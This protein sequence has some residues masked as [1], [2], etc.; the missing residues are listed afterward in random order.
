MIF[1]HLKPILYK[2]TLQTLIKTLR[3]SPQSVSQLAHKLGLSRM[4]VH[5]ILR[6]LEQQGRVR[7]VG[8]QASQG[9]RPARIYEYAAAAAHVVYVDVRRE[10]A[11]VQLHL[12]LLNEQGE[13]LEQG[14]GM[15]ARLDAN[16]LNQ[17]LDSWRSR[18]FQSIV[19]H[20][21]VDLLAAGTRDLLSARYHCP[22]DRLTDVEALL[23]TQEG[24][25]CL[26]W[27]QG[28][29]PQV[30]IRMNSG[31]Y[32]PQGLH[33]LPLPEDW[34]TLD[35]ENKAHVE[36]MIARLVQ[37]LCCV[38][39]A[40]DVT[41]YAECWSDRLCNR[42][43]YNVS[44]KLQGMEMPRLFFRAWDAQA[45]AQACRKWASQVF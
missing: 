17:W 41:L 36:E 33:C 6:D 42:V 14:G 7:A 1:I 43:R 16:S 9:G 31:V 8:V 44:T 27:Q 13:E 20:G 40:R 3:D 24:S 30:A 28:M 32:L 11:Y 25:L 4:R 2:M 29:S 19:L 15:F 35:Y 34:E 22:V 38:L 23:D 39:P 12:E 5:Q 26:C 10:T 45:V 37:L 18:Q 21:D